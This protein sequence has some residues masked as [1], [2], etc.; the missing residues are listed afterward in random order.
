[1]QVATSAVDEALPKPSNAAQVLVADDDVPLSHF[2]RRGLQSQKY[3]VRLAHD[4]DAALQE[5]SANQYGLLILK[6]IFPRSMAC[7]YCRACVPS[8]PTCRSWYSPPAADSKTGSWPWMAAPTI[9]WSSLFLSGVDR[10]H[11]RSLAPQREIRWRRFAS[12][13]PRAESGRVPGRAR[14]QEN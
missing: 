1:M 8:R 3:E 14:G 5:I 9:I 12:G 6:S 2:L 4:G 7:R 13:R 11:S 10:A